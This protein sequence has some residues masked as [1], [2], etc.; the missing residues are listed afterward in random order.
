MIQLDGVT[1]R[2]GDAYA[3]QDIS[4]TAASEATTLLIGPSGSGKS[5]LLRLVMGL[6]SPDAGTVTVAGDRLTPATA[7]ALRRRMGYV[8]QEGGLFPH[9]TGRANAA[10]MARHL[11]WSRERIDARI[12]ELT[13]LVQLDPDRLAQYPTEL[14]GG[15]RQRVSLMRALMLDP[16]VLLLDEP[17]GALDPMIRADLQDDLRDIFR[18]LGKTVVF[19]THDIGEAAFF[20][21]Q[22]VL[23]REGQIEQCGAMATLLDDPASPFVTDFIQAQRAPL[24]HLRT[25]GRE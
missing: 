20:G 5:T 13:R 8:I 22:I 14:S 3:V 23:L 15:Q 10:L 17:L 12:E 6:T 21:D 2:Y 7:R 9:L 1:K 16:D 25:E 11:D 4:L 19:V 24:E 18:R